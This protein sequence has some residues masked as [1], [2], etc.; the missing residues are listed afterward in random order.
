MKFARL[1]EWPMLPAAAL[2]L[3]DEL[4][5]RV[6][7]CPLTEAPR[8]IAAL[9][10]TYTPDKRTAIGGV[11]VWDALRGEVVETQL[12]T[13]PLTFPYVPGLLSFRE[14]P[15]LLAAIAALRSEPRLFIC[16][17][18]GVA[19]PRRF[20]LA[21]HLGLWL[22]LPTIGCAKSRLFGEFDEPALQRGAR[23]WLW[24]TAVR[25][26]GAPEQARCKVGVVLRTRE[27]VRPL[28]VS[29]GH[30]CDYDAAAD[31]VLRAATR[32]RLPEPA[33]LAHNLVS[34]AR[35]ERLHNAG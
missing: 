21:C 24:S 8:L 6:R 18:Q 31:W 19:H 15:V 34:R 13:L 20:G 16:D 14:A 9:D 12:A 2:Q 33:R 25:G 35:L 1:H 11:V 32:V 17:G 5:S 22:K 4:A 27:A 3:Q 30:L 7:L 28:F 26:R 10:A 23:S 29:P